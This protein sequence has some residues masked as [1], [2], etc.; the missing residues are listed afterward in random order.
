MYV[1]RRV[2]ANESYES[3][4][5]DAWATGSR[6]RPRDQRKS[7]DPDRTQG[8]AFLVA[9]MGNSV[10]AVVGTNLRIRAK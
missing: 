3:I 10:S 1:H 8:A 9:E 2:A 7:P 5:K 4:S 6:I